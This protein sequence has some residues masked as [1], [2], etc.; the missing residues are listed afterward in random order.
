[1]STYSYKYFN[2]TFPF[3]NVAHVE[4]NRADKLNAFHTEMWTEYGTVF[5]ALSVD[6]N[7]RTIV[8]SGAGDR[9]FS[10]G[11]DIK[12]GADALTSSSD[13]DNARTTW[14]FKRMIK[15]FQD[16]IGSVDTCEKPVIAA[17]HGIAFGLAIDITSACDIRVCAADVKFSVK[18][19]DIGIAADIGT[20]TRLPKIVGNM[21]WVKDVAYSARIF[22]AEEALKQGFVSAV[23][24]DKK[25][26]LEHALKLAALI[27][28]K[29]PVA[30]QGTKRLIN[31]SV[32]HTVQEGLD[33]TQIWNAAMIQCADPTEAIRATF[34]KEKPKF[35]KL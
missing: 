19:V 27:A 8:L 3:E 22:G 18:E 7:V 13:L 12:G 2:V 14:G 24:E 17:V 16:A 23:L 21:S 30:V 9:A 6:P 31:Y 4:I 25:K 5:S 1:M 11:L 34:S 15:S 32:D 20:L 10:A 29:S 33:Y 26:A 35:A 28:G